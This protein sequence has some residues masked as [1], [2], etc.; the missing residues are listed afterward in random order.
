MSVYIHPTAIVE[1]E[2]IGKD[3]EIGPFSI[4]RK[5]VVIGDNTKIGDT[6]LIEG[7]TVLG[8]N[9][10]VYHGA[11]I[12]TPP[13]D[14]QYKPGD[15]TKVIIGDNNTIREFATINQST[16]KEEQP[17]EVGN[18]CLI[19]AYTHLGH[20]TKIGNEVILANSVNLAGHVHVHD[21]AIIGGATPVLQFVTIGKYA[22]VGGASGVHQDLFPY[23]K[24]GRYPIVNMGP[25]F[26]GLRRRGFSQERRNKIKKIYKL[27]F[28]SNLLLKEAVEE[29]DSL[30]PNDE[31]VV[32]IKE[33]LNSLKVGLAKKTG[34]S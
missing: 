29:I 10:I 23:L 20:N 22:Y 16:V 19:M 1:S 7:N 12:G 27:I 3:V 31:D 8:R 26:V 4:V 13:Q 32:Y 2:K 14:L 5:D 21:Y 24:Y 6:V 11:S 33:F 15:K 25:N 30:F 34:K 28:R 9:N 17:T 18:K